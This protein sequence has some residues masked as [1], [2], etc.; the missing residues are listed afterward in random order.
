MVI[1]GHI[2]SSGIGLILSHRP[3]NRGEECNLTAE[4]LTK[5]HLHKLHQISNN[6]QI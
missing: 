2:L 5:Q 3:G 1:K 4:K 6:K